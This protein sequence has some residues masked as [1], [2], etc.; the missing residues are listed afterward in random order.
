[1]VRIGDQGAEL[2][3]FR[4]PVGSGI[5]G[6]WARPTVHQPVA[7]AGHAHLVGWDVVEEKV[8]V[9]TGERRGEALCAEQDQVAVLVI[10]GDVDRK[11]LPGL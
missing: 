8:D 2:S 1:M 5:A 9:R 6:E 3:C 11:Q 7:A 10:E 4:R